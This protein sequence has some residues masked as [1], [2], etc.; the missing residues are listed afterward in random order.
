[1]TFL[2]WWYLDDGHLK[3]NNG[4]PSKIN[5]STDSFT[6]FENQQLI[7][8]LERKY[9]LCFS[10]DGQNRLVLYDQLQI[11]YFYRMVEPFLHHSMSRKMLLS[12]TKTKVNLSKRTTLYLPEDIS[13]LKPTRDINNMLN[14]LPKLYE[15][16][17]NRTDYLQYYINSIYPIS[18]IKNT[19]SYQII[20]D[21]SHWMLLYKIKNL[22]G[23]NNSQITAVCFSLS[24][25]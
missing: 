19:K 18:K 4:I 15:I 25:K 5:L 7:E 13:I 23:L 10:L 6:S 9:F 16:V 21:E 12:E 22:T 2:V 1:M 14:C 11:Y 8:L 24:G 3:M 20:I 17:I